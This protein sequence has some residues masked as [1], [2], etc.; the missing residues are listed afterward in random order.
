M[1]RT[2][3]WRALPRGTPVLVWLLL[4]AAW[5]PES[6]RAQ[7]VGSTASRFVSAWAREDVGGLQSLMTS[8]VRLDVEGAG[9]LGVPPRQAAATLARLFDRYVPAEPETVRLR[10]GDG[11]GEGGFAEFRWVPVTVD[12]G[13]TVPYVIF[14]AFRPVG[15]DLLIAEL[16]VL[17]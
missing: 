2:D 4:L 6:I 1:R 3:G 16:R 7:Q 17:R 10:D 5:P 14:V 8:V 11:A 15:P 13:E 9:H 12:T